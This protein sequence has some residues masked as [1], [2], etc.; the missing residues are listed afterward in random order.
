MILATAA[1]VGSAL[2]TLGIGIPVSRVITARNWRSRHPADTPNRTSLLAS[3]TSFEPLDLGEDP[4]SWPSEMVHTRPRVS[5]PVLPWP[6]ETWDDEYFGAGRSYDPALMPQPVQ[7]APPARRAT[8]Q[9][10]SVT[11][12]AAEEAFFEQRQKPAP[13][14]VSRKPQKTQPQRARSQPKPQ[15]SGGVP[16]RAEVAQMV[17]QLGLAG[18]VQ[19]IRSK[20][21]WDFKKAAQYLA[22][23]MRD[24]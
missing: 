20:T 8:K 13:R 11:S 15:S 12:S 22:E 24:R 9:P 1:L 4:L 10:A 2:V 6:S 5:L 3:G 19:S 16:S 17:D 7:T 21:G 23:A 18:A 14:Q